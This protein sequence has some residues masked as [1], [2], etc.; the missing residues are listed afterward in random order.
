MALVLAATCSMATAATLMLPET[1]GKSLDGEDRRDGG[2]DGGG[3]GGH[4]GGSSGSSGGGGGSGSSVGDNGG[5]GGGGAAAGRAH[6][7]LAA[8]L[9]ASGLA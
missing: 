8:Q 5:G 3:G 4:V 2:G 1:G 7:Q 6:G 9:P